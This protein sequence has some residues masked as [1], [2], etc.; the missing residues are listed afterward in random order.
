MPANASDTA[1]I[2]PEEGFDEAAVAGYL[3]EHMADVLGDGPITF[4][5]FP[6]GKAN[7]TY[8]AVT[9]DVEL[10]LRRAPLGDVARALMTWRASSRCCP[11]SGGS[12]RWRRERSTIARTRR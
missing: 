7:L 9:P 8:R 11:A 6:G 3:L 10:V 1:P 5:Q 2:R 12:S 4:D